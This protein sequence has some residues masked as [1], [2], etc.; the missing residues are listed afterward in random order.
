LAIPKTIASSTSA[1]ACQPIPKWHRINRS[2]AARRKRNSRRGSWGLPGA[3][4]YTRLKRTNTRPPRSWCQAKTSI[5]AITRF[6]CDTAAD[7]VGLPNRLPSTPR[8]R[9]FVGE[10]LVA[11]VPLGLVVLGP[12]LMKL[13]RWKRIDGGVGHGNRMILLLLLVR[14]SPWSRSGPAA[15]SPSRTPSWISS[16]PAGKTSTLA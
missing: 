16:M 11:L 4:R 13:R 15:S 12:G 7:A 5:T 8:R 9:S 6:D 3:R 2:L 14:S 1:V 10:V